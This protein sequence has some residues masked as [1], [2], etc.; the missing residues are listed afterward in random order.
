M[1][2][3]VAAA[4]LLLTLVAPPAAAAEAQDC[5][6]AVDQVSAAVPWPQLRLAP[7]RIWP[8]TRGAS[9]LVAVVDTGV[10]AAAPALAG[11]VAPGG[12]SFAGDPDPTTDCAGRGTFMAGIIAAQP[13]PGVGFSGVAP[14]ARIL[15]VRVTDKADEVDPSALAN[16][17]RHAADA[18]AR[19]IAVSV[20]TT[21]PSADLEAAV[22]HAVALDAVV[23]ADTGGDDKVYPAA[24]ENVIGVAGLGQ[25]G[26]ASS[27]AGPTARSL[28][29]PDTD[30]QSIP[31][32]GLGHVVA[33]GSGIGVAFAAGVAALV[34][35][36]RPGLSAIQVRERLEATADHPSVALPDPTMGY[37]VVDPYA[38]VASV[39]PR[40]SGE[41]STSVTPQALSLARP[42]AV[43]RTP[44]LVAMLV[45]L[46][47]VVALAV[48]AITTV[49]VR[50]SRAATRG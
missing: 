29:A 50:R 40:E 27:A 11:V 33:S 22:T 49:T 35:S 32:A 48:G 17:I 41:P 9:V 43:D 39:L 25:D 15:P 18:G 1:K 3:V 10:S 36:Y 37:G 34:R 7:E 2:R 28:L 14:Q 16:G 46:A 44:A 5:A 23:L 8:L 12:A 42:P 21:T 4:G 30:V 45:V 38:A 47:V 19:V 13:E 24:Y 31:P 26:V 6:P 20:S